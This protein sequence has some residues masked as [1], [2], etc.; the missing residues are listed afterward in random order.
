MR[1]AREDVPLT[2]PKFRSLRL[3]EERGWHQLGTED[4]VTL[5]HPVG[6]GVPKTSPEGLGKSL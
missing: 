5:G 2:I 3:E 1:S 4:E 6:L